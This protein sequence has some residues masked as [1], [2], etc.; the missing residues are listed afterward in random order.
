MS[1]GARTYRAG[2]EA[3][4]QESRPDGS[5][6]PGE[7]SDLSVQACGTLGA[8]RNGSVSIRRDAD[9]VRAN[10]QLQKAFKGYQSKRE[11]W[12]PRYKPKTGMAI[13]LTKPTSVVFYAIHAHQLT[14]LRLPPGD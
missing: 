11:A 4:G 2:S 14:N 10:I 5:R 3:T 13:P 8:R 12:K 1:A 9:R 6:A 7:D